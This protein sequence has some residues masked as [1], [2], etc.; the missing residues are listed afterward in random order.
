MKKII[1]I[2]SIVLFLSCGDSNKPNAC[3]ISEDF[4]K[5]DLNNPLTAEFSSFDC[6]A[7]ENVDGTYTVL[8]K[9][10]AANSF[11]VSKEYIYKV[12]LS[13]N[14]AEWTDKSNWTLID[15]K[16]EEYK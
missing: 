5:Q 12:R 15:M 13:F 14:G 7:E 4:I 1:L 11:G 3:V 10:S 9:V 16:S 8:R 2:F 6:S